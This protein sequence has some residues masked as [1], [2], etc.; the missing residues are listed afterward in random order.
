MIFI[1]P[2]LPLRIKCH[3]NHLDAAWT[4]LASGHARSRFWFRKTQILIAGKRDPDQRSLIARLTADGQHPASA[5]IPRL[6]DFRFQSEWT[7]P[8]QTHGKGE[9][10]TWI[11]PPLVLGASQER[12]MPAYLV[13]FRGH[14]SIWHGGNPPQGRSIILYHPHPAQCSFP[15]AI[16]ALQC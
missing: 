5:Y 7:E 6:R 12:R 13:R 15:I 11:R 16:Y 1:P 9:L 3:A 2:R 14:C 10:R 4:C 8:A